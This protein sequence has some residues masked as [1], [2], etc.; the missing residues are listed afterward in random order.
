M[1]RRLRNA[2]TIV[3]LLVVIAIIGILVSLLLPA[4][5]TAR[6]A[7]RRIKCMNNLKQIGMGLIHYSEA[8]GYLPPGG[9]ADEPPFGTDTS[10]N[11]WW[12]SSWMI[13]ILPMIEQ[14]DIYKQMQ[15]TGASGWPGDTGN[16][17]Y[18]VLGGRM[19]STYRC[20]SSTLPLWGNAWGAYGSY[21]TYSM[22]A[23]YVGISGIRGGS[24]YV[25]IPG[26]TEKR[27]DSG[28]A[29]W[30]SA[31]GVLYPNSQVTSAMIKD[32]ASNTLAVSEQSDWLIAVGGL[33]EPWAS[34]YGYGFG[35]G[36]HDAAVPPNYETGGDTRAM[37]METIQ[38]AINNKNNNGAGWPLGAPYGYGTSVGWG[39]GD[40]ASTGVG[41]SGTNI[42][43]NSPHPGGVGALLCD[44]SVHFLSEEISL[45]VLGQLATRDDGL[46]Q[47][48]NY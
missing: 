29:G 16:N 4:V 18:E 26:Y 5:Q 21:P 43:L 2:F 14:D 33:Q 38:Y 15:F 12:G 11:G 48:F 30:V 13:Y 7:A 22:D 3:E 27:A 41:W 17:A 1:T 45:S 9:A 36:A 24:G 28:A 32:G 8:F 40:T 35:I 20:A 25:I 47:V 31:G 6:E 44:G 42:P 23:S 39:M 46:G 34:S 37:Q 19:I 10:N